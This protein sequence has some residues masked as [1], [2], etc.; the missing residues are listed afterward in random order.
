MEHVP[1]WIAIGLVIGVVGKL[2]MPGRDPGGFVVT[3]LLGIAGALLGGFVCRAAA[4]GAGGGT[5][6]VAA[7]LGA[8]LLLILYRLVMWSRTR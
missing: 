4:I 8:A 5:I 2:A 1:V 3:I 7:A 6:H